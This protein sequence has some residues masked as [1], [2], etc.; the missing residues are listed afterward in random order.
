MRT[1]GKLL[2]LPAIGA[3]AVGALLA[4]GLVDFSAAKPPGRLEER[5]ARFALDRSIAR[6]SRK[7]INPLA[8]SPDAARGGLRLFRVHCVSCHGGPGVDPTE[9]GASLNPP[10]PGLTLTR[11]QARSDGQLKW[12]VSNGIR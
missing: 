6:H 4:T 12:I 2:L 1:I 8:D 10:A 9:G 11:V 3:L 5:L 7:E